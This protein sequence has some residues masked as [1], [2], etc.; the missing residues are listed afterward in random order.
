MK[1]PEAR[2]PMNDILTEIEGQIM[3]ILNR[4]IIIL[5]ETMSKDDTIKN[6]K[7]QIKKIFE[8]ERNNQPEV[9]KRD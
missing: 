6:I 9:S 1:K 8:R 5:P 7:E 4:N 3:K 2:E